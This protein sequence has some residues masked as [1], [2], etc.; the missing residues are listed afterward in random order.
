MAMERLDFPKDAQRLLIQIGGTIERVVLDRA[1]EIIESDP[2]SAATLVDVAAIQE[3]L[4][5]LLEDDG[6]ELITALQRLVQINDA[7][8]KQA[9]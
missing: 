9:A 5:K 2:S 3:S 7:S 1:C 8:S 4:R 6:H